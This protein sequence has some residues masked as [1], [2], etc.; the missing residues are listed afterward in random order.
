MRLTCYR[1]HRNDGHHLPARCPTMLPIQLTPSPRAERDSVISPFQIKTNSVVVGS[2]VGSMILL[3]S[4]GANRQDQSSVRSSQTSPSATSSHVSLPTT[5]GSTT[6]TESSIAASLNSDSAV[7]PA[8]FTWDGKPY[9]DAGWWFSA[10]DGQI[11]CSI[12]PQQKAILNCEDRDWSSAPAVAANAGDGDCEMGFVGGFVRLS[13][14][15]LVYGQCGHGELSPIGYSMAAGETP[16]ELA[17][18]DTMVVGG[19]SCHANSDAVSCIDK[20]TG[21]GFSYS[22]REYRRLP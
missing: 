11:S 3:V 22:H 7:D 4:C 10:E 20:S 8:E 9:V 17:N 6:V 19:Y 16:P 13:K 5:A 14:G 18:G 12:T 15:E 1:E 2:V 21:A